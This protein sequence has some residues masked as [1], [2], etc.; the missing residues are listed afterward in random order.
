MRLV[1]DWVG[2]RLWR[3][4]CG[5]GGGVA[6]PLW[7]CQSGVATPPPQW[8]RVALWPWRCGCAAWWRSPATTIWLCQIGVAGLRPRHTAT[9]PPR[10][11]RRHCGGGVATPLWQTQSG[12]ATPPPRP[13]ATAPR[14]TAGLMVNPNVEVASF[15]TLIEN[16]QS[17]SVFEPRKNSFK[18]WL[19][20]P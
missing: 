20:L 16:E 9:P 14:A 2:S 1:L 19:K 4:G 10:L 11:R 3:C 5:R 6:T 7:L 13:H 12:V 8:R 17:A 15:R 18:S